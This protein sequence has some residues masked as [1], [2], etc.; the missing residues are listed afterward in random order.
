M[1]EYGYVYD[2]ARGI[3]R[4]R[5]RSLNIQKKQTERERRRREEQYKKGIRTRPRKER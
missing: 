5:V 1:G 4:R 2:E 3:Y